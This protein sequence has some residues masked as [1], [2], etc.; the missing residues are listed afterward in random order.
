MSIY[1]KDFPIF[2]DSNVVYLDSAATSQKPLC[3]LNA[4]DEYYNNY[5]ANAHRGMYDWGVKASQAYEDARQKVAS[6]INAR[7][8]EEIIFTK[9]ASEAFNLIANSYGFTNL[10]NGDEIVLSITEHHSNLV[11][12]QSI[13]K[14]CSATLNY[15]YLDDDYR[16]TKQEIEKKITA[17]T[18]I[19]CITQMSNVLGVINDVEYIT[20]YAH[21]MGAVVIVD[22]AQS[23]QHQ[24]I[25]VQSIN[26]DFLVFSGHKMFAPMGTGVL[27]GK[28]Q[29]LNDM[30]PFLMGGDMVEYVYEQETSFAP[31]PNKFEAG[32]QNIGGA[33][34]LSAAIDYINSI[35]YEAIQK[36]ENELV[37]YAVQEMQKLEFLDLYL[38]KS[39][40]NHAGVISFNIKGVHP[41]DISDILNSYNVCTRAGNHCAQPL[42]RYLN[43][44]ATCRASFSIYNTKQDVDA[45]I[46]ALNKAY[47]VFAKYLNKGN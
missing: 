16:I 47:D 25:D 2:N 31:L 1:K 22:A 27:Y 6:F 37:H 43:I 35:G 36:I 19:V 40:E 15:F 20:D 7:H 30:P 10:E 39:G 18:K 3:V 41:H 5:N 46:N 26:A 34:G 4:I 29:L 28:R 32:T 8:T 24:K 38:P 11:P 33:V 45:L 9:N 13:A 21:K 42:M 12:W 17:K 23:V 14:K 44:Q